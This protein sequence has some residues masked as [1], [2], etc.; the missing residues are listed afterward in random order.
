MPTL[1]FHS[2]RTNEDPFSSWKYY[3]V[4]VAILIIGFINMYLT[5]PETKGHTLEG[6]REIFDGKNGAERVE[7][8]G[9]AKHPAVNAA[10]VE[11]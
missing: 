7:R 3:I 2:H 9:D 1:S 10:P 5:Y 4:Y 6:I 11:L 8:D